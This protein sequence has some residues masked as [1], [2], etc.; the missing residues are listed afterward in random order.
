M[1]AEPK[2]LS[3]FLIFFCRIDL[4]DHHKDWFVQPPQGAIQFFL[5]GQNISLPVKDKKKEVGF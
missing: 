1:P 4:V 5:S 3:C 2:K